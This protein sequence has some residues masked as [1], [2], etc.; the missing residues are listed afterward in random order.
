LISHHASASTFS[1]VAD[2][3]LADLKLVTATL[4]LAGVV[5]FAGAFGQAGK[6]LLTIPPRTPLNQVVRSLA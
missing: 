1:D 6:L 2:K 4:V 3:G 5:T